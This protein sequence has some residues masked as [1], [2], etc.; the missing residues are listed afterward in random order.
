MGGILDSHTSDTLY[1]YFSQFGTVVES[2][3]VYDKDSKKHRGFGFVT[4]DNPH[5]VATCLSIPHN[6]LGN[7]ID[8]K[9]AIV[10]NNTNQSKISEDPNTLRVFVGGI[11]EYVTPGLI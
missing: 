1:K 4:F 3:V 9:T 5:V 11:A 7:H 6:I 10:R 8:V 2:I